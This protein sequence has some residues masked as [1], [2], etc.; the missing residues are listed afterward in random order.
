MLLTEQLYKN[1]NRPY[2]V[3]RINNYDRT[4]S[5]HG[6]YFYLTTDLLY[7]IFYAGRNGF[8]EEY[9][10]KQSINI[11]N[12]N[13][14]NDYNILRLALLRDPT[15]NVFTRYLNDL[16]TKD[17]TY[18]LDGFDN[19]DKILDLLI[20]LGYD[21]YF[22]YEYTSDLKED[23]EN[24]RIEPPVFESEPSIGVLN[25]DSFKKVAEYRYD[26][27]KDTDAFAKL[28]AMEKKDAE[29]TYNVYGV[30]NNLPKD[31]IK[32]IFSNKKYIALSKKETDD[33]VDALH[34]REKDIEHKRF[35]TENTNAR[36][37]FCND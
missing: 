30:D 20:S 32:L 24:N 35:L 15:L 28:K 13:S 3:G 22:N 6:N 34:L 9:R 12:A 33:L 17:W 21:G 7:A 8:I 37:L 36:Y 23:L 1:L 18:V 16:K 27:F 26:V 5:L 2:Y 4:K 29:Y 11:F 25:L 14:E 19:R 10:L 31:L